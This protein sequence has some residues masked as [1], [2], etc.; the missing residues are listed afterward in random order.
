MQILGALGM[1]PQRRPHSG[2]WSC[3]YRNTPAWSYSDS[4][5]V[6]PMRTSL[7]ARS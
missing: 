1:Q 5:Q 2:L 3:R 4:D 6:Y 7:V